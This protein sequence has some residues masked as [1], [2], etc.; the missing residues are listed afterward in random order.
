[1][2]QQPQPQAIRR[3]GSGMKACAV[4]AWVAAEAANKSK[5]EQRVAGSNKRD[6]QLSVACSV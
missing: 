3:N 2:Q 6:Q 5:H 4:R 1:M